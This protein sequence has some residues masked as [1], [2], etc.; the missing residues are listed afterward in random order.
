MRRK[1]QRSATMNGR[2]GSGD[3]RQAGIDGKEDAEDDDHQQQLAHEVE[4]Q[5][6]HVGEVLRVGGDAADDLAGGVLI[7]EGHVARQHGVEGVLAQCPA[8]H[9]RPRAPYTT[10][11]RS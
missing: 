6:H 1:A 3:E 8:P 2:D 4:R 5:R 11:E 9:R 7:V 10:G